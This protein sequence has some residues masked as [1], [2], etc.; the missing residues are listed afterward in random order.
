MMGAL[1]Y[2]RD[3]CGAGDGAEFRAKLG[4]LLDAEG[5]DAQRR[6][7]LAGAYNK[8]F[9]DYAISYHACG[10]SANAVIERYLGETARLAADLAA[11]YGG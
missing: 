2:L 3:L 1:A 7:L 6:D 9:R 8:A 5:V 4:A 11:R 10:P